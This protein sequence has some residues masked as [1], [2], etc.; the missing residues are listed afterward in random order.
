MD[1]GIPWTMGYDLWAHKKSDTTEQQIPWL[2]IGRFQFLTHLF[3]IL[4]FLILHL[5]F[6]K[7]N[8][9]MYSVTWK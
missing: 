3:N 8:I 6:I 1:K 9:I 4:K 5:L 7:G 2:G